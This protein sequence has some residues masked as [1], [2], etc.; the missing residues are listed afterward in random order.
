M[1]FNY[2]MMVQDAL[3]SVVKRVLT[4]VQKNGLTAPN[5]FYISFQTDYP[6]VDLPEPVRRSHP[7][8]ITI[9]LQNQFWDLV[10]KEEGFEV[11]LTFQEVPKKIFVPFRAL[12]GFS[13]PSVRFGLHF[14]PP[15][16]PEE[17]KAK[18][19]DKHGEKSQSSQVISLDRFRKD[20][21]KGS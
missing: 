8:N 11:V 14:N 21:K 9:V 5:H 10:V 20:K 2:E 12:L 3:R 16:P 17:P 18:D 15:E 1:S 13:D 7:D 6:G 4:T 19:K